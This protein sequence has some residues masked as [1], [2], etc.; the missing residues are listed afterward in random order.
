MDFSME[1]ICTGR[2][3]AKKYRQML[4]DIADEC[5]LSTAELSV[6]L[7]LENECRD[8]AREIAE[9]RHMSKASVSKAVDSL[10]QKEYISGKADPADRRVV[11]LSI[12][13][14]ADEVLCVACQRQIELMECIFQDISREDLET[15]ERIAHQI[16]RNLCSKG[17]IC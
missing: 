10:Y 12:E 2:G 5:Q 9:G 13:K 17:R 11:H 1:L 3:I 15:L 8:T 6:L 4:V 16:N 14:K 7:F